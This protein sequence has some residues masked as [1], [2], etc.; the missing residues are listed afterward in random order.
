M[1]VLAIMFWILINLSAPTWCYVLWSLAVA[2]KAMG[3]ASDYVN[4]LQQ[5][6]KLKK[7]EQIA[8][9]GMGIAAK[10]DTIIEDLES[11]K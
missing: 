10:L 1:L 6:E 3:M 8:N 11:K 4:K 2:S 5:R 9:D 7:L